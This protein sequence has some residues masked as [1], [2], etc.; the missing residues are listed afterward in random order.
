MISVPSA[1]ILSH[2]KPI[3]PSLWVVLPVQAYITKGFSHLAMPRFLLA[4]LPAP[5]R[6]HLAGPLKSWAPLV[7]ALLLYCST[8]QQTSLPP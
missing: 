4:V 3:P 2:D 6:K 5:H 7:S 8:V 1:P